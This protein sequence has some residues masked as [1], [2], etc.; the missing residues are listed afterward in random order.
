MIAKI[1]AGNLCIPR[2]AFA[3]HWRHAEALNQP[4][5]S[6]TDYLVGV[7]RTCRWLHIA[8]AAFIAVTADVSCHH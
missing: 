2:E 8:V 6:H 5:G 1:P 4:G 3:E 7:I